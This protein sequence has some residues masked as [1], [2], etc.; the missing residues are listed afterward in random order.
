MGVWSFNFDV[1]FCGSSDKE[2]ANE[3]CSIS[4]VPDIAVE[5]V[6]FYFNYGL[7]LVV[8]FINTALVGLWRGAS[9]G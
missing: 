4:S 6:K 9:T 8:R 3:A 2:R 7:S 5:R 1:M